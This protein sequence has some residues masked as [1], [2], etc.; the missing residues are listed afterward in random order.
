MTGCIPYYIVSPIDCYCSRLESATLLRLTVRKPSRSARGNRPPNQLY[1]YAIIELNDNDVPKKRE[2][3]CLGT[4]HGTAQELR[5]HN[6][7]IVFSVY[8]LSN[9]VFLTPRCLLVN[10]NSEISPLIPDPM[11]KRN[12]CTSLPSSSSSKLVPGALHE[13]VIL[14]DCLIYYSKVTCL[15]RRLRVPC[16]L[17][18]L[19]RQGNAVDL[20][21]CSSCER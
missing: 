14:C 11:T 16:R 4:S 1:N 6:N 19:L 3:L 5:E 2:L 9:R 7:F 20:L 13:R 17:T 18:V 15:F 10:L 8:K 21:C 12:G